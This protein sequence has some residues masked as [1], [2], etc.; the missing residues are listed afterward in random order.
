MHTDPDQGVRHA[1]AEWFFQWFT[2]RRAWTRVRNGSK[3]LENAQ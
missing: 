1:G 2:A 3:R